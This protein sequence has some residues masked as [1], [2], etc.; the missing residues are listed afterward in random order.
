MSGTLQQAPTA[1]MSVAS[2]ASGA[3]PI[4]FGYYPQEGSKALSV[5]YAWSTTITGYNEDL[6]QIVAKGIE[7]AIQAVWVDNS[8]STGDVGI[9]ISGS[10]QN[11]V[12]AAGYQ[13]VAPVFFT[14]TPAFQIQVVNNLAGASLAGG[15]TRLI[16]LNVP[17][18]AAG[19]WQTV[20]V[21]NGGT[22]NVSLTGSSVVKTGAGRLAAVTVN[23]VTASGTITVQDGA[24]VL[25]T[26]PIGA[27][28]GTIYQLNFPFSTSLNI[29]YNG[30]ATGTIALA[31]S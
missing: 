16:F 27:T 15:V 2:G 12:V 24:T 4:G 14:G 21:A 13:G 30:G 3:Y 20:N 8:Q 26:I 28:V 22:S 19:F 9:L 1:T 29:V 25:F 6:S 23:V 7:T 5:Q 17:P 10:G 11:I 31:Y 18:A